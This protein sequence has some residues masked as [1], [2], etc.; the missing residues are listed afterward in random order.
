MNITIL[1][2]NPNSWYIFYIKNLMNFLKINH[3]LKH[4]FDIRTKLD[5][6]LNVIYQ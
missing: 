2:D 5:C 4:I 3:A 1:N 6:E